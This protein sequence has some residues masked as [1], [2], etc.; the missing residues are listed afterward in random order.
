MR[1]FLSRK[2]LPF[3]R[4]KTLA[5]GAFVSVQQAVPIIASLVSIVTLMMSGKELTHENVF[6]IILVMYI[7]ESSCGESFARGT[8]VLVRT[9]GLLYRIESFLLIDFPLSSFYENVASRT[10]EVPP[11]DKP[12]SLSLI[13]VCCERECELVDIDLNFVTFNC[14]GAQLV[15]LTGPPKEGAVTSLFCEAIL[16]E[17]PL[18]R[19]RIV[20]HG[21]LAYVGQKPW[22]FSGTVRENIVFGEPYIKES[23]SAV[24]RACK[25]NEAMQ[26]L[27]DGDMTKIGHGGYKL[28]LSQQELINVARASY[29]SASIVLMDNPLSHVSI[30]VANQVFDDCILSFLSSRLRVVVTGRASF[31]ERC[32]RVLLMVDGLIIREGSLDNI[33]ESGENLT[34]LRTDTI[35]EKENSGVVQQSLSGGILSASLREPSVKNITD[36][37][38]EG[39]SIYLR[40]ARQTGWLPSLSVVGF[41]LTL[42]PGGKECLF[43]NICFEPYFKMINNPQYLYAKSCI[44]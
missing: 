6:L 17:V 11:S 25:L 36:R 2:E 13:G 15:A 41:L 39:F 8:D 43:R 22:I 31:L 30:S 34:W 38:A 32:P 16:K 42:T 44:R 23:Y 35:H 20:Q 3:I 19:G 26:C 18:S 40:Y 29:S 27:P 12:P 7:L 9:L 28:A 37:D 33:R 24:L 5:L 14:E 1:V 4:N 10:S 21:D